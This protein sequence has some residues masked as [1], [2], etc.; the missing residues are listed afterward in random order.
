MSD[1]PPPTALSCSDPINR[2][3][4]P[5][6]PI[7]HPEDHANVH[8]FLWYLIAISIELATLAGLF[9]VTYYTVSKR[10]GLNEPDKVRRIWARAPEIRYQPVVRPLVF[11]VAVSYGAQTVLLS[12]IRAFFSLIGIQFNSFFNIFTTFAALGASALISVLIY[13]A[14]GGSNWKKCAAST[15]LFDTFAVGVVLNLSL[16]LYERLAEVAGIGKFKAFLLIIAM[17]ILLLTVVQTPFYVYGSVKQ[18]PATAR[19]IY[20]NSVVPN[21]VKLDRTVLMVS[22]PLSLIYVIAYIIEFRLNTST[23]TSRVA[24][25][26]AIIMLFSAAALASII[27]VNRALLSNE[28]QWQWRAFLTPAIPLGAIDTLVHLFRILAGHASFRFLLFQVPH[29]F[30][31]VGSSGAL[32]AYVYLILAERY[33]KNHVDEDLLAQDDL[34]GDFE[35]DEDNEELEV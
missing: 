3:Q 12:L 24:S 23:Y 4:P 7:G 22:L 30:L 25:S 35:E 17:N 34:L 13:R 33:A 14:T 1:Y 18:L 26:L 21:W 15:L 16:G 32:G 9:I 10:S 8:G 28:F 27:S 29:V 20:N 5:S 11:S 6:R 31:S 2:I 19:L